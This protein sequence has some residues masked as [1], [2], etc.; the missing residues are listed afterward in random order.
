VESEAVKRLLILPSLLQ[1]QL[2]V[3]TIAMA[4][5]LPNRSLVLVMCATLI[6]IGLG[7]PGYR[8]YAANRLR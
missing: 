2:D 3:F 7:L 6:A 4:S 5:L 8:E 1:A